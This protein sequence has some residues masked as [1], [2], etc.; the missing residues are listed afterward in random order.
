MQIG[1]RLYL[2]GS[3]QFA[4]SHP[5]DCNCYLIDGG[6]ELGL[7][8]TG[9]GLGSAEIYENIRNAGFDPDRLAHILITHSHVGHWGGAN[10]LRKRTRARV[11]AHSDGAP[12]MA[13]IRDDPGI[14]LNLRFGRYP[15]GFTPEACQA[16]EL[17]RE[18]QTLRI[19]EVELQAI[20]VRGHTTDSLCFLFEDGG[21]RALATGD[22]V[23]YGGKIGLLNLEGC[24]F[25]DYRA[26]IHKLA[27]MAVDMLLP[28]HGVFTM[29][30]GQRHI[31][32]AIYKLSDFV[33]PESFFETNELMWDRDYLRMMSA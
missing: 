22:V 6:S 29:R 10:E 17:L 27:G 20:L 26:D 28:G 8:D 21:R 16:D 25:D 9:L 33:L 1:K 5:L 4:I 12:K 2:V 23:F 30:R 7:I 18:G 19:G 11:W 14:R 3:E 31:D 24:S 32:R 15:S 13:D